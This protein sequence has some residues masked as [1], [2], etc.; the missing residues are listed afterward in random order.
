MAEAT[1]DRR[2][3]IVSMVQPQD[4]LVLIHVHTVRRSRTGLQFVGHVEGLGENVTAFKPG[5][6]VCGTAAEV[7]AD[8][9]CVNSN[10]I[11]LASST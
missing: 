5:D 9:V 6:E 3:Q 1:P 7:F 2:G 4:D 10:S 8:Y 11:E